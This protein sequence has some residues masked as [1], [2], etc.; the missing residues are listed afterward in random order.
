MYL[1]CFY[2]T[3]QFT[4][5]FCSTATLFSNSDVHYNTQKTHLKTH[6]ISLFLPF[7]VTINS[8]LTVLYVLTGF[9]LQH[10]KFI[11]FNNNNDN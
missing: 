5:P 4:L 10:V 2:S 6:L 7:I 11:V 3:F 1:Q 8:D 9:S